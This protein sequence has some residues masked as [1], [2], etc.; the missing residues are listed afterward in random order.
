MTP[1]IHFKKQF[2]YLMRSV[3]S[4]MVL[5][6]RLMFAHLGVRT[7]LEYD[8]LQLGAKEMSGLPSEC[9]SRSS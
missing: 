3:H 6:A 9:A 2:T 5:L 7:E 1:G 8:A 4:K